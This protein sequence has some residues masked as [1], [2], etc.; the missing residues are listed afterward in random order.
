MIIVMRTPAAVGHSACESV[1]LDPVE[2]S[3]ERCSANFV[4]NVIKLF[5]ITFDTDLINLRGAR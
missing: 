2:R 3:R 4:F 5:L 1:V